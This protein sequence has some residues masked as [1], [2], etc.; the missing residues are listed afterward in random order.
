MINTFKL[1]YDVIDDFVT[2]EASCTSRQNNT[3]NK[4][5]LCQNIQT[6]QTTNSFNLSKSKDS[7]F[8]KDFFSQSNTKEKLEN[9]NKGNLSLLL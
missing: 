6:I 2:I 9:L 4:E 1:D 3:S 8:I 5:N 7:S